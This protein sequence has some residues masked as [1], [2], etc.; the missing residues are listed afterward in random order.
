MA[1]SWKSS[2]TCITAPVLPGLSTECFLKLMWAND[3]V[4]GLGYKIL[5]EK[6]LED[7]TG[8]TMWRP[9][10]ECRGVDYTHLSTFV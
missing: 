3:T 7:G 2:V 9:G 4:P 6:I 8:V 10:L 5:Q 1:S